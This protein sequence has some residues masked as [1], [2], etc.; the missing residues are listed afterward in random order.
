MQAGADLVNDIWGLKYDD[1]M[2]GVIAKAGVP[3]CL[4]HN[5]KEAVYD[6]YLPDVLDDLRACVKL[7][8][9]GGHCG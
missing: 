1:K 9:P 3:C 5:R 6:D 2:A 4:M 8:K 7:A